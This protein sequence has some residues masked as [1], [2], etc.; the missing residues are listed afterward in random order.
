[1]KSWLTQGSSGRRVTLL[2]WTTF[3][4]IKEALDYLKLLYREFQMYEVMIMSVVGGQPK[5]KETRKSR[6]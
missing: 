6:L 4:H 3:L 1:M 5:K 2:P